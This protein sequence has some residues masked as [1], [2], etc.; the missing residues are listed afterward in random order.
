LPQR[1]RIQWFISFYYQQFL[2]FKM[3]SIAFY[4]TILGLFGGLFSACDVVTDP[5]PAKEIKPPLNTTQALDSAEAARDSINGPVTPVQK[6]LLEDYTGH[7]CG[8]CPGAAVMAKSQK[9]QYGNRLVVMAVHANYFAKFD[10]APYT[11]NFTTPEGEEWFTSF[12]FVSN[13]NGMV[14]RTPKTGSANAVQGVSSWPTSIAEQM[15]KTP[16][17]ALTLTAMEVPQ[18]DTINIKVRSKYLTDKTGKF[19]LVVAI[20]Q[21]SIVDWQKNYGAAAGGDPSYNVGDVEKYVHPHVMRSVVNGTWGRLNKENPKANDVAQEYLSVVL[22]PAWNKG[23]C[24]VVAFIYDVASKQIVQVE[25]LH[26]H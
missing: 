17:I 15:A 6:V 13:P 7:T 5:Y 9:A 2:S 19:N 21:D 1:A 16:Q 20:T 10:K 3:K 12:G 8:N 23:K 18:T 25:E 24:A 26:L 22:N 11:T 14:N 4:I